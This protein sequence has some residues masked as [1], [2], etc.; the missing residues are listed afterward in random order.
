MPAT[1]QVLYL[2]LYEPMPLPPDLK[3]PVALQQLQQ[4]EKL[5]KL[6]DKDKPED[7]LA[8]RLT[9]A[10]PFLPSPFLKLFWQLILRLLTSG[11]AAF[12]ALGA[13][14]YYSGQHQLKLQRAAILKSGSRFGIRSRQAGVAGITAVLVG[15]GF[16]RLVN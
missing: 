7:C 10:K 16:W 4:P 9:G 12:F 13:Y 3:G 6:L 5:Q 11:S 1:G 8:C 2:R 14:S 15:M